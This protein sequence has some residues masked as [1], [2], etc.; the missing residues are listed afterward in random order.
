MSNSNE[1]RVA[2]VL[3]PN[4]I[5]I[6]YLVCKSPDDIYDYGIRKIQPFSGYKYI[7]RVKWLID[8]AKP[9]IVILMDYKKNPKKISKRIQTCIEDVI[10]LANNH[11]LEVYSYSREQIRQVFVQFRARTK[12]DG[13]P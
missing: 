1:K 4:T 8:Y 7:K 13:C 11:N 12:Y 9:D 3:Y 2:L 10:T 6:G 5:G